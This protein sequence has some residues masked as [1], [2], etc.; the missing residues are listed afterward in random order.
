MMRIKMKCIAG[1]AAALL[2][3]GCVSVPASVR[4]TSPTP[5][6]NFVAVH[7]AP[8]LYVGQE[9]RF[10]GTVVSVTNKTEASYLE[11]AVMPLDSGARP[12][13]GQPVLGRI[14]AKSS[15]FLDP[16]NFNRQLVTVVGPLTGSVEGKIGQT[17][18]NFVTMDING[19]QR[20]QVDQQVIMPPQPIGP[21]PWGYDPYWRRPYWGPGF[22]PGWGWY[23]PM[24]ARIENVV[25]PQ[26]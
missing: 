10:G 12:I 20:W 21:G 11:I 14:L 16:I 19:Y 1:V 17:P 5:Q 22:G 13:L 18:Y 9:S 24:P 23:A 7:N 8:D 25:V 4:G 15:V 2:L 6:Q 3:A 26:P